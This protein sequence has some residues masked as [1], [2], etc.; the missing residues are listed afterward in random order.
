MRKQQTNVSP[1][2]CV[3][4][5]TDLPGQQSGDRNDC[6]AGVLHPADTHLGIPRFESRVLSQRKII[7][8]LRGIA[9]KSL[10]LQGRRFSRIARIPKRI[11]DGSRARTNTS[12]NR[13]LLQS[14]PRRSKSLPPSLS[15][16]FPRGSR[17]R[18]PRE[19]KRR[20][21]KERERERERCGGEERVI[22]AVHRASV[23]TSTRFYVAAT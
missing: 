13:V 21:E 20:R 1:S 9:G 8:S 12:T 16:R 17:F 14:K 7:A 6:D 4:L 23:D 11:P 22:Q 15:S 19:R 5:S 2:L 18:F 10:P 3:L